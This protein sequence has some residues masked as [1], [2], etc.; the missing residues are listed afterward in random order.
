[1][2]NVSALLM[3]AL[4]LCSTLMCSA[5]PNPAF[6]VVITTASDPCNM[7]KK[8]EGRLDEM[9]EENCGDNDEDCLMRRSL[10]AH[11]DYIYTQKKNK[12][13]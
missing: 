13:L 2:A 10:V 1:M 4:L 12:N 8:M 7:E 3:I 11:T 5:R 9:A 6:T